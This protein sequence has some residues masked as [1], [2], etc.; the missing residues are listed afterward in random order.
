M[1]LGVGIYNLMTLLNPELVIITG[2]GVQAG[3]ALFSHMFD[4]IEQLKGAKFGFDQTEIV[5]KNWTDEDWARESGS[6][7]LREIY[8]SPFYK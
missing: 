7:V 5:I 6:L 1:I 2:K 8:K 4:S 3:E